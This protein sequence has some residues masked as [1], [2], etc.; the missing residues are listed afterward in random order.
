MRTYVFTYKRV[1]QIT[2]WAEDEPQA[3][4]FLQDKIDRLVTLDV[5]LPRHQ[6]SY[7]V[8]TSY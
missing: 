7:E 5:E 6:S 3:R 4:Q 8:L 2:I 1:V